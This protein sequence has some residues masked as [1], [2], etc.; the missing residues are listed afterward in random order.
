MLFNDFF[1]SSLIPGKNIYLS[2]VILI[3][4]IVFFL[5]FSEW[6]HNKMG[7]I[8]SYEGFETQVNDSSGNDLSAD[9]LLEFPNIVNSSAIESVSLNTLDPI[10]IIKNSG[11]YC[12]YISDVLNSELIGIDKELID[13]YNEYTNTP[14]QNI[15]SRV[16]MPGFNTT[17]ENIRY[18]LNIII[19][20]S[21]AAHKSAS[22]IVAVFDNSL[23]DNI[24]KV[25]SSFNDL[26]NGFVYNLSVDTQQSLLTVYNDNRLILAN[27]VQDNLVPAYKN[28]FFAYMAVSESCNFIVEL[29][30]SAYRNMSVGNG[31]MSNYIEPVRRPEIYSLTN[32]AFIF[33]LMNLNEPLLFADLKNGDITTV[34][35]T[36]AGNFGENYVDFLEEI[37]DSFPDTIELD[38]T[39]IPITDSKPGANNNPFKF[40]GRNSFLKSIKQNITS[41]EDKQELKDALKDVKQN[42]SGNSTNSSQP[43]QATSP[44]PVRTTTSQPVQA[45]SPQPVMT[46]TSQPV[47]ATTV[48]QPVQATQPVMITTSQPVQAQTTQP[49]QT[50]QP[51]Q[52]TT[53]N[54]ANPFGR[55]KGSLSFLQTPP[56]TTA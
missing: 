39:P 5:F 48:T 31:L 46:T 53:T 42:Q 50:S 9:V 51:V 1:I 44:Q 37:L 14:S 24:D 23:L 40:G 19:S 54:S 29:T 21:I 55:K 56:T 18:Y 4:I 25:L 28:I 26:K 22:T 36:L 35:N 34:S 2:I 43:V 15:E 12:S 8:S 52:A 6:I 11:I 17:V 27:N 16:I 32:D 7:Y 13:A 45:T 33:P 47:Q 41:E 3:V 30:N 49:V 20:M 10:T 38:D